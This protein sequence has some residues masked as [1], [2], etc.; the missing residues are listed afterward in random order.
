[1]NGKL[2]SCCGGIDSVKGTATVL[3]DAKPRDAGSE[4][5]TDAENFMQQLHEISKCGE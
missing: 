4:D 5:N 1:M 3:Q 2:K